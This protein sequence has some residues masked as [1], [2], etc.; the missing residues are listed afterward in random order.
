[1][2]KNIQFFYLIPEEFSCKGTTPNKE[3]Y[4][5][6]KINSCK[7][8]KSFLKLWKKCEKFK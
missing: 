8:T 6:F 4:Q 3:Q 1:M 2:S 7:G 5:F